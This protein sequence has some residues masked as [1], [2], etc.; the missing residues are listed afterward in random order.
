MGMKTPLIIDQASDFEVTIDLYNELDEMLLA[1]NYTVRGYIKRHYQA[2]TYTSFNL[3][4]TD[5]E[6][7][8][9]VP[10][11]VSANLEAARYV[12][13]IKMTE[14]ATNTVFTLLEGI[15]TINPQSTK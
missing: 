3:T 4:L 5:G 10:A 2:N 9:A 1:N 8:V 15:I 6:L 7:K 13:D 11:D 12:Y 14:I